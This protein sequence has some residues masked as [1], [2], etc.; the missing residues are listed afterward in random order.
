MCVEGERRK[1]VMYIY[2]YFFLAA[3]SAAFVTVHSDVKTS[4][5]C[6]SSEL[7]LAAFLSLLNRFNDTNG[8]SLSHVTDGETTKRW[9]LR[10]RLHTH[11]LAGDKLDD[12]SIT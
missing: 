7:T 10:I 12:A 9:V 8:N 2:I 4:H 1:R 6:T 5:D 3:F 11:W